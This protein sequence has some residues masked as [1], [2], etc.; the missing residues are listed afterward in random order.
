[1]TQFIQIRGTQIAVRSIVSIRFDRINLIDG[2]SMSLWSGEYDA[3]SEILNPPSRQ[4]YPDVG[5]IQF[6]RLG[7]RLRG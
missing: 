7:H 3:V 4:S 5:H 6:N 2:S 1:M